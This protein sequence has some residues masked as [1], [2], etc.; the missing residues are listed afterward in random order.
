MSRSLGVLTL[1]LIAKT[2]G[3][4][5]G[6]SKAERASA[7]SSKQFEKDL[8][9]LKGQIKLVSIA[10]AAGATA[11]IASSIKMADQSRKTAQSIGLTTEALTGLQWAAKQSGVSNEELTVSFRQFSRVI[12]DASQGLGKGQESFKALGISL[13]DVNGQ[14]KTS[15]Q[16]FNEAANS[17]SKMQDGFQKTAIA[18]EL[19][20]RSG[21]K[22]IPMLNSGE[23]GIKA[24]TDEAAKLGLSDFRRNRKSG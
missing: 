2:S 9:K 3:F 15:E 13:T 11:M 18:S 17:I 20:G 14:V 19:F 23:A 24:L 22:L 4:V 7:K 10:F 1:D 6:L 12:S 5:E 21:A 8:N 16:L